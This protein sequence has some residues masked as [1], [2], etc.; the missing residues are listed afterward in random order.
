MIYTRAFRTIVCT[1]REVS[2]VY[3][4]PNPDKFRLANPNYVGYYMACNVRGMK[5][6]DHTA[7]C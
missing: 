4:T 1:E 2:N 3:A 5:I 6:Q 7:K